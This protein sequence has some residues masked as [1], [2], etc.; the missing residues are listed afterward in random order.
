MALLPGTVGWS[1][2]CDCGASSLYLLFYNLLSVGVISGYNFKVL[3]SSMVLQLT[4]YKGYK[5]LQS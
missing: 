1:G 2:V 5:R 4:F 3:T